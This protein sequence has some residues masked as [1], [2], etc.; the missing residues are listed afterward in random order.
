M[1]PLLPARQLEQ[2][3]SS[4]NPLMHHHQHEDNDHRTD[5]STGLLGRRS[6]PSSLQRLAGFGVEAIQGS[7]LVVGVTA[8]VLSAKTERKR[9][10]VSG[11]INLAHQITHNTAS[12]L[13][14]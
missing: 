1:L 10:K 6:R 13:T 12:F 4:S 3:T 11:D 14:R 8:A 7:S 5:D 9:C 2:G